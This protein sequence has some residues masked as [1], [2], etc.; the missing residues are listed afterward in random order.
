MNASENY[1]VKKAHDRWSQITPRLEELLK[2][3]FEG[4]TN[5]E[6]AKAM[7]IQVHSVEGYID[8]L[9]FLLQA[10]NRVHLVYRALEHG[11][12][13][14]PGEGVNPEFGKRVV[15]RVAKEMEPRKPYSRRSGAQH[16]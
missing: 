7:G 4:G 5:K 2:L 1:S 8:Q 3:L 13:K 12:L 11:I 6:I 14:T 9:R 10:K 16:Q 15:R